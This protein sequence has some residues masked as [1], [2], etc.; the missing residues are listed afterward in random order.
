GEVVLPNV[1]ESI[2]PFPDS[3]PPNRLGLARWL[4]HPDHPLTARVA[5]NRFW[6]LYF[7]RG[8][9]KNLDDFGN[10]GGFPDNLPIL[11]WL[12]IQFMKSGWDVKAM[13][14]MIVMSAT[15]RQSS[16]A[17]SEVQSIDPENVFLA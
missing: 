17:G 14:K 5:V 7:G 6:Q 1:P 11:D 4:F 12:A 15:Y 16:H 13:Q 10:Q 3:F 8:I 2:L 9:H